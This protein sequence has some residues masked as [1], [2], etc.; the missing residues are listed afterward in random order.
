MINSID[1]MDLYN[2]MKLI[3]VK[4]TLYAFNNIKKNKQM[5]IRIK[6][7]KYFDS[8]VFPTG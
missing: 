4:T 2:Y 3:S 8:F 7:I 6:L 1:I 5:E